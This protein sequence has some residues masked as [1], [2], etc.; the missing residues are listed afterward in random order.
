MKCPYAVHA[1][2]RLEDQKAERMGSAQ[3][4]ERGEDIAAA[5]YQIT[6]CWNEE[7][8]NQFSMP[9]MDGTQA[10]TGQNR[11]WKRLKLDARKKKLKTHKLSNIQNS[12]TISL[13]QMRGVGR[14][15]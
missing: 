3:P 15:N 4:E 7:K 2:E 1:Q 9:V 5:F 14:N 8:N 11:S 10:G 6:G 12:K 13:A